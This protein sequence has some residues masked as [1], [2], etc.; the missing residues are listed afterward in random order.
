MKDLL[1]NT[2]APEDANLNIHDTRVAEGNVE[3][4][5]AL[6]SCEVVTPSPFIPPLPFCFDSFQILTCSAPSLF[7]Q[8]WV[9]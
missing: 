7:S 8:N 9:I 6:G 5:L 1:A 4:S 3:W 2:D